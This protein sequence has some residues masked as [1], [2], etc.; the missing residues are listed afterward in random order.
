M[1]EKD[2]VHFINKY[3]FDSKNAIYHGGKEL[4]AQ[5]QKM[6]LELSSKEKQ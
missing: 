4:L 2:E 5:R 1:Y 6:L 3:K